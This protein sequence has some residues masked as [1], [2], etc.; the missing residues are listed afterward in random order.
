MK[1]LDKLA[2]LA[3]LKTIECE[4]PV[5]LVDRSGH[6]ENLGALCRSA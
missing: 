6:V 5:G 3:I 2:L 1:L 4:G